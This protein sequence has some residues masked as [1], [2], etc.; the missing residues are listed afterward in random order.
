MQIFFFLV[1]FLLISLPASV[2]AQAGAPGPGFH[3]YIS[4]I[5]EYND[6]IDLSPTNEKDD[7][8][9]TVRPGLRYTNMDAAAGIDLD[10]SAGFVFYGKET[11]YNFVSHNASLNAKYL[12]KSHFNFYLRDSFIR[13]DESRERE[14]FTTVEDNQYVLAS[15]PERAVYWR[16]VAAPTVEYQFGREDRIGVNYRNNIYR[17]ESKTAEDSQENYINPFIDYWF[18]AKNGLHLEYG[19]TIGDFDRTPDMTGHMANARYTHRI[20]SKAAIFG[21]YTFS[22]RTFDSESIYYYDYDIHEPVAGITYAFSPTLS[23]SAQVGY[24]WRD[25]ETGDKTDGV[26]YKAGVT[27][28]GE[29]TI[30]TF[31]LQGGYNED[32]F[33][34]ENLGFNRYH[35]FTGS[36]THFPAKSVSVGFFG[37]VERAEYIDTD[38]EDWIW[39]IGGNASYSPLR[40]LKLSLEVA[41]RENNSDVD[42]ND[43]EENRAIVRLTAMY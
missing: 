21:G 35:R 32:Y 40:W 10:Y 25:P 13:S 1:A 42:I 7:F 38:R 20:T 8:I 30:Y 3:P 33:T 39:Q 14:Y 24:F 19:Y 43:Y 5:E 34:S 15:R 29:R 28:R 12:T 6:N 23:A 18:D 27:N 11:D 22:R 31:S 2:F 17:T 26:S 9:T 4:V 37:S 36:L 16:N 41:H